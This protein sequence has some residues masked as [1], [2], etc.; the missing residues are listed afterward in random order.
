MLARVSKKIIFDLL[1]QNTF[2]RATNA[3]YSNVKKIFLNKHLIPFSYKVTYG[4]DYL[5]MSTLPIEDVKFLFYDGVELK[6][7]YLQSDEYP[8][9]ELDESGYSTVSPND[10]ESMSGIKEATNSCK[11]VNED[12][13]KQIKRH[14]DANMSS[15]S[16]NE[17]FK[18]C[19]GLNFELKKRSTKPSKLT[20]QMLK[21]CDCIEKEN[22]E[23]VRTFNLEDIEKIGKEINQII[24]RF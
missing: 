21:I 15:L 17:L 3:F 24:F 10:I 4:G 6:G 7:L 2:E 1:A 5:A 16:F 14:K 13:L 20:F 23:V 9:K 19:E 18:I 8:F 12:R 11:D 22:G